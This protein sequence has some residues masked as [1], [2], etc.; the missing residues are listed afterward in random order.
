MSGA[1]DDAWI[2][3]GMVQQVVDLHR[4]LAH[5]TRLRMVRALSCTSEVTPNGFA[6]MLGES[7]Q[8]VSKHLKTLA[9]AGVVVGRKDGS[10]MLYALR[11]RGAMRIVDASVNFV[12]RQREMTTQAGLVPAAAKQ[13]VE[14][15][16][17]S[18]LTMGWCNEERYNAR[19]NR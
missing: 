6:D 3:H 19:P 11:D 1:I 14:R 9:Q 8:N 18:W 7:Q 12:E 17:Q 10:N 5:P 16:A 13:A 4:A 2:A 15:P